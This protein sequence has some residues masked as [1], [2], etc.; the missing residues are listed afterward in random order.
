MLA[1]QE[2]SGIANAD[3]LT[4][5]LPGETGRWSALFTDTSD[6]QDNGFWMNDSVKASAF[7]ALFIH[8]TTDSDGRRL[9]DETRTT[10]PPVAAS[11]AAGDFDFTMI[12]VH[13][14]FAD[15]ET[16]ESARELRH[17]LDYLDSYF[18]QPGHDPDVIIG[19]DFNIPSRLSGQTGR[20]GIVLDPVFEDDPRF[21]AGA[22]R[23]VSTVHE[24]T[25]R[26]PADQGG[27]PRSNY[28]H[29]I[30][31]I[32][33]LEELIQ[34]RRVDPGVL[35]VDPDDPELRLTSDH[36]PIVALFRT[37]GE[38]VQLDA[39]A[40]P[41]AAITGVVNGASFREGI[42]AGSWITIF[43]TE[44][45]PTTRIWRNDEIVDGALPTA[46]DGVGV[47]VNGKPAAT[48]FISPGQLNVQAPDDLALGPVTVE[49]QQDGVT[50]AAGS[51]ELRP[52]SP[53]LFMFDPQGRK[54]LAAVHPDGT[55]AGPESLFG[56]AATTRPVAPG[57]VVLLFGT[58]FG[59]TEPFV[60]SGKVF[61]GAADLKEA[62]RVLVGGIQADVIFAGL[63]SAGLNQLNVRVPESVPLGDAEVI[64][65]TQGH[66]TQEGA[67]LRI[68]SPGTFPAPTVSLTVAPPTIPQGQS[69]TL[70]WTTSNA[71]TVSID[72]GIGV[73]SA[74]GSRT[75]SPSQTTTYV[76]T[77]QGAGGSAAASAT[78]TV[79]AV[80]PPTVQLSAS[81]QAI[82]AGQST[83]LQ[84]TS[85]NA[86]TVS[87]NQGIGAV[88]LDGSMS[89]SPTQTT[90]YVITA[91][92][93]GGAVTASTTVTLNQ[94][95]FGPCGSKSLCGQ[96][97]SCAEAQYYLNVCKVERLDADNDGVP[98][99]SICPG[100]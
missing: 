90:T 88:G 49:V 95:N 51:A 99:E 12:G 94:G 47:L 55:F 2:V 45:A 24:P 67:F 11:F 10:H 75:V 13:L 23:L 81:P 36:L 56:N 5:L 79:T 97:V 73:V 34:A 39:G 44:L 54:Y 72:Q 76:I 38:G 19:G 83:T 80:P 66:A 78:V 100:G 71:T 63:S 68:G 21:Q 89:V 35:T 53:S 64:A 48:Y 43:G 77:A 30:L 4:A 85:S 46:L 52:A 33:T 98:C 25:S 40:S 69:A 93:A 29:F 60:S 1:A 70:Q 15:G 92:G 59:L 28:D 3:V 62:V 17:V 65:E 57:D 16:V 84:W 27:A 41:G 37:S 31:S 26:S 18:N 20:G 14:T 86:T 7:S 91:E 8:G 58:G 42:A 50:T 96:M 32:D 22:R 74:N 87:I 61:S 9:V 82:Q 6:S